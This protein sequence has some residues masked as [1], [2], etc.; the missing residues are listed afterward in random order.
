MDSV[1]A[2]YVGVVAGS[3]LEA[4]PELMAYLIRIVRASLDFQGL[5]WVNYDLA[6]R[7]HLLARAARVNKCTRHRG[8]P[9]QVEAAMT[10]YLGRQQLN[11]LF[12][13]LPQQDE[14]SSINLRDARP[15]EKFVV[16]GARTDAVTQNAVIVTFVRS[17]TVS[18]QDQRSN[19][20]ND[21]W[22]QG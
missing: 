3:S 22:G 4:V 14:G 10:S 18:A 8:V 11:R 19:A 5:S 13:C 2:T 7:C 1:F 9:Q 20:A 15:N 16:A 12:W 21:C 6:F 17:Q